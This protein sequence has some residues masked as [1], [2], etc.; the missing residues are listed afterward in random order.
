MVSSHN[1]LTSFYNQNKTFRMSAFELGLFFFSFH[2]SGRAS[3]I[4]QSTGEECEQK[5]MTTHPKK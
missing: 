5:S 3:Y 2:I 4:H 1:L